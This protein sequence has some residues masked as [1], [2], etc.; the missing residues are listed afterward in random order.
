MGLSA[1]EGLPM[2]RVLH[3][4]DTNE[5]IQI[6]VDFKRWVARDKAGQRGAALTPHADTAR[7]RACGARRTARDEDREQADRLLTNYPLQRELFVR[8]V[9]RGARDGGRGGR[10]TGTRGALGRG[11]V[12][13]AR[14]ARR[15]T[16]S[17]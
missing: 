14:P 10:L 12:G 13:G 1:I 4:R 2:N 3:R 7:S 11:R 17:T 5:V 9:A 6:H 15:S 16:S 8:R